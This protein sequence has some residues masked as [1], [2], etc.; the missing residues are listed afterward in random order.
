[1]TSWKEQQV[2]L[3]LQDQHRYIFILNCVYVMNVIKVIHAN[4]QN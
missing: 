1:M 4:A 3:D 2:S